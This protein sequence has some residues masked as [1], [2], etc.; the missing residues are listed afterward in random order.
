VLAREAVIAALVGLLLELEDYEPVFAE[1]GEQP[2]EAIRRL[3]PPLIVVL[4][5]QLPEARSDLFFARC[6]QDG[7]SVCL[8]SEPVAAEEVRAVARAR[9]LAFFAMPVERD[10]LGAAMALARAAC[11]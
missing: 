11:G 8:F 7:A 3:R 5:G 1:P 2:A 9:R 4:D 6:A 10:A